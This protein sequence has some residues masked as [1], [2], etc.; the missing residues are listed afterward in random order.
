MQCKKLIKQMCIISILAS[1]HFD[2]AQKC[3][4]DPPDP[5]LPTLTQKIRLSRIET[6][7]SLQA[8]RF[9]FVFDCRTTVSARTL[10]PLLSIVWRFNALYLIPARISV[11]PSPACLRVRPFSSFF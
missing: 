7:T 9:T 4:G 11:T 10:P 6:S 2:P 3:H 1:L 5:F 8:L